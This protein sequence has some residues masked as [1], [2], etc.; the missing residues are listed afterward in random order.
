[1]AATFVDFHEPVGHVN[2]INPLDLPHNSFT[3]S[4]NHNDSRVGIKDGMLLIAIDI[5][6]VSL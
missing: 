6:F 4:F 2:N 3:V 1:M 5:Q